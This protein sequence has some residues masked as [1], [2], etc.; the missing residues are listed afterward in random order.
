MASL[1]YPDLYA[2]SIFD[3]NPQMLKDKGLKNLIV[4]IDN[5]L[6]LWK[7]REPDSKVCSWISSL[8]SSG[9]N[10]CILSNSSSRRISTYCANIDVVYVE[11][12]MKPF[13]ISYLKAM[14]L[15][16]SK[17][18][19]TCVIGD[20]IFTDILGGKLSGLFTILVS[21]I[22]RQEFFFTKLL[23]RV[24]KKILMRFLEKQGQ[25]H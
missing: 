10:I 15:L 25:N 1:L 22:D 12:V 3:I 8:K 13:R 14:R 18:T 24:E 5:T 7:A 19:D 2:A 23:R 9:F 16:N 17:Y 6:S 20:Q 21:P 11:N 4:D